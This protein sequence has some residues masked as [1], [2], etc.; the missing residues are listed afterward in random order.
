MITITTDNINQCFALLDNADQ[1]GEISARCYTEPKCLIE[2]DFSDQDVFFAELQQQIAVGNEIV[3]ATNYH[4]HWSEGSS[5]PQLYGLRALVFAKYLQLNQQEV[6]D[7]LQQKTIRANAEQGLLD[8]HAGIYWHQPSENFNKYQTKIEKILAYIAAG[9]CYQINYTFPWHLKTYGQPTQLYWQL[10]NRQRVPYGALIRW[11]NNWT[12]SR[13]PELFFQ[14]KALEI[15][16]KPM[17]GTSSASTSALVNAQRSVALANDSKNRAENLMI[18]DLLRNDLGMIADIGSVKVPQLFE[19]NQFGDVLQMTST[20]TAKLPPKIPI[21]EVFSALFPCGSITGAPKRRAM[22]IIESLE[23]VTRGLYTGSIGWLSPDDNDDWKACFSVVIRTIELDDRF[24]EAG[25]RKGKMGIGSGIVA[26]SNPRDEYAEC[27]Q[28]ANFVTGMLPTVQLIET[29]RAIKDQQGR[30]KIPLLNR[31]IKRLQSSAKQLG[32]WP[33]KEISAKLSHYLHKLS[34]EADSEFI[35]L[36]L[37]VLPT[38]FTEISHAS[39]SKKEMVGL[40]GKPAYVALYPEF[41]SSTDPLR[42]HKTTARTLYNQAIRA[43][44]QQNLYE[45]IFVNENGLL[46]EGA[47][48]NIYLKLGQQ[49]FT[50]PVS[51]GVLPGVVRSAL[52]DNG[53]IDGL[54]LTEKSLL[55]EDYHQAEAIYLSNG[56][57]WL[58]PVERRA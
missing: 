21:A 6:E 7:F 23:D 8:D 54:P 51:D 52:L 42:L 19:V 41:V 13:S 27:F 40:N 57:A 2:A 39:F 1:Q 47:K 55:V 34:E 58:V 18:V 16:T 35:R 50:P 30:Y 3:L 32:F 38:G 20:V 43:S 29:M 49:W 12:L 28:K 17:K 56:F 11:S 31:H 22:E 33:L 48:T 25:L 15:K 46:S 14:K 45:Y 36:R 10:M 44:S 4:N 37:L 24:D 5:S 53:E 26:D 9:D